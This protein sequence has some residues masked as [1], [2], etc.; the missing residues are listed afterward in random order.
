[1]DQPSAAQGARYMTGAPSALPDLRDAQ[2]RTLMRTTCL[3]WLRRPPPDGL[4]LGASIITGFGGGNP[5]AVLALQMKLGVHVVQADCPIYGANGQ[6]LSPELDQ[7]AEAMFTSL[8]DGRAPECPPAIKKKPS[9][10]TDRRRLANPPA[11]D[12]RQTRS[13]CAP[14]TRTTRWTKGSATRGPGS[15][16]RRPSKRPARSGGTWPTSSLPTPH[17]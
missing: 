4:D 10:G 9:L 2:S 14:R 15:R 13:R 6:Q 7:R 5:L 8:M 11:R 1:M 16:S 17:R 3:R 12:R